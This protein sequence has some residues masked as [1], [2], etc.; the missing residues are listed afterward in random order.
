ME[1]WLLIKYPDITY[2]Q[3]LDPTSPEFKYYEFLEWYA[4]KIENKGYTVISI[5]P[6]FARKGV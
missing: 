6:F 2:A 3:A 4:N 5:D 1:T